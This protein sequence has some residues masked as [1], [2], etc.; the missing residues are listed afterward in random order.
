MNKEEKIVFL[1]KFAR[2]MKNVAEVQ[3]ITGE[4]TIACRLT[5]KEVKELL[6][7]CEDYLFVLE[8]AKDQEDYMIVFKNKKGG[9]K[10]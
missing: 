4:E 9:G 5:E 2:R 6:Y 3:K 1:A 8:H 7:I 10:P